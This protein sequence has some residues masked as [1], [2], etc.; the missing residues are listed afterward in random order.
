MRELVPR[1]AK[2]GAFSEVVLCGDVTDLGRFVERHAVHARIESLDG[3]R[4]SGAALR[5]WRALVPRLPRNAVTFFPHWDAPLSRLPM[6]TVV[7]VHDLIYL[8]VAGSAPAWK[9]AGMRW[10]L[11]RVVTRA[12][13]VICVSEHGRRDLAAFE[14]RV[15][16]RLRVILNGA[17]DAF[18]VAGAAADAAADPLALPD[19]VRPPYLLCVATRKPHKN[20]EGAVDV[21]AKLAPHDPALTLVVVGEDG[22]H[23]RRVV[24]R[25]ERLGVAGRLRAYAPVADDQL[26]ALYQAAEALLFPSTYEGFGLPPLEAMRCGTP[27]IASNATS[28]PEVTG[29]AALL[30][31]PDDAAGMADAVLRLRASASLRNEIVGRGLAR[32]A[33]FSWERSAEQTEAAL[34]DVAQ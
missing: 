22:P 17:S 30:F 2:R 21:L 23:W 29:S 32:A 12:S 16:G 6:P 19:G 10:W 24:A 28:I 7:T 15:A 34:L 14:P 20:L 9:R 27:V 13:G 3:R 31:A 11:R 26:R 8:R 25:A 4:Y 18:A 33:E 1:L 5:G